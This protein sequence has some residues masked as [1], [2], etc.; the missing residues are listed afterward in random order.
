MKITYFLS[1]N[2]YTDAIYDL[3]KTHLGFSLLSSSMRS[4][5]LYRLFLFALILSTRY[6]LYLLKVNFCL[7]IPHT[8]RYGLALTLLKPNELILI[9][10]G[11][12]FEYWSF[13]HEKYISPILSCNEFNAVLGSKA[14]FWLASIGKIS[15]N[16]SSRK[17]LVLK[18]MDRYFLRSPELPKLESFNIYIDDGSTF[19]FDD[20]KLENNNVIVAHPSR[21]VASNM[22][23]LNVPIEVFVI[24]NSNKIAKIAG[25]GST[26]LLNLRDY[27]EKLNLF[28]YS[29]NLQIDAVFRESGIKIL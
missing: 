22:M 28:S 29:I 5:K 15:I 14:P 25:R 10:D 26:S 19:I 3:N 6:F 7:A 4:S 11:I 9:D 20:I 21:S 13:F 18:M 27:S 24:K 2:Y 17:E 23:K 8:K 1:P 12:T 16:L